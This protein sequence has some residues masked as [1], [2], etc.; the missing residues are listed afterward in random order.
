M[1]ATE[2]ECLEPCSLDLEEKD[3]TW[4]GLEVQVCGPTW[5][6]RCLF[7]SR[8]THGHPGYSCCHQQ[9]AR[10]ERTWPRLRLHLLQQLLPAVSVP[11]LQQ[12][13]QLPAVL[14]GLGSRLLFWGCGKPPWGVP[15]EEQPSEP[16]GTLCAWS[17]R[18]PV[19]GKVLPREGTGYAKTTCINTHTSPT[20]THLPCT[21][22]SCVPVMQNT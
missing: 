22:S 19:A 1:S 3:H 11:L 9:R 7:L 4:Q 5:T 6:L 15:C 8:G 12:S 2:T 17:D 18:K 20:H 21:P 16:P 13:V 14:H 10:G